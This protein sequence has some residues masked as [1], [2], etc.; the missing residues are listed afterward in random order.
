M[1]QFCHPA[2][3]SKILAPFFLD[4]FLDTFLDAFLDTCLGRLRGPQRC[5]QNLGAIF[6]DTFLDTCLESFLDTCLG[7]FAGRIIDL[8]F[9]TPVTVHESAFRNNDCRGILHYMFSVHVFY[10]NSG[11]QL[12]GELYDQALSYP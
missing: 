9:V 6:L 11:Q 1:G 5:I 4:T 2:D 7:P 8:I 10:S 12:Y 3:V